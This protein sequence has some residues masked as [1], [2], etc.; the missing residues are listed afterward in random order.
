MEIKLDSGKFLLAEKLNSFL[1]K[2]V[3]SKKEVYYKILEV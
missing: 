1:V 3:N 2:K